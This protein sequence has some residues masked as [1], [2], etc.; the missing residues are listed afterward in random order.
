MLPARNRDEARGFRRQ[1]LGEDLGRQQAGVLAKAD[2]EAAV[3]ELLGQLQQAVLV[4]GDLGRDLGLYPI[5]GLDSGLVGCWDLRLVRGLERRIS[6]VVRSLDRRGRRVVAPQLVEEVQAQVPIEDIEGL[7]DELLFAVGLAGQAL[8]RALAGG[9]GPEQG[10]PGKQEKKV[11]QAIRV[12]QVSEEEAM[13]VTLAA[14]GAVEAQLAEITDQDPT[15]AVHL[16]GIAKG[17]FHRGEPA[18]ARALAGIQVG[19]GGLEFQHRPRQVEGGAIPA[20]AGVRRPVALHHLGTGLGLLMVDLVRAD[21]QAIAQHAVHDLAE[22][23][24]LERLFLLAQKRA[25]GGAGGPVRDDAPP[26]VIQIQPRGGFAPGLGQQAGVEQRFG[27]GG[28][29][30]L[31]LMVRV[32]TP[33]GHNPFLTR[34]PKARARSWAEGEIPSSGP[35]TQA[36]PLDTYFLRSMDRKMK[37]NREGRLTLSEYTNILLTHGQRSGWPYNPTNK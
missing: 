5:R 6:G 35:R 29:L 4:G 32:V 18:I 3:Q 21:D 30:A 23:L 10:G 9:I 17:L 8:D 25:A 20:Q 27:H 11:T 26:F 7:G 19:A 36:Y 33:V 12:G 15:A 22:E 1:G 16:A 37:S 34:T 13:A 2:E 14:V 31:V 24:T 28:L